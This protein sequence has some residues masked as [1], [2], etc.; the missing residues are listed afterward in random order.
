[1]RT[2]FEPVSLGTLKLRNRLVMSPMTR[3][4]CPTGV[5]TSDVEN[6]YVRRASA[7]VGLIITEGVW[8]DH[9]GASNDPAVPHFY[10]NAAELAWKKIATAIHAV[11]GAVIPQLWHVGC[12]FTPP[13][14]GDGPGSLRDDQLGP[15]GLAGGMGVF[16]RPMVRPATEREISE[17]I[18][19]FVKGGE[20][21]YRLGFDGVA[22][23]AAHGY[24]IDQFF[25]YVT[26]LRT[27]RYGG[28]VASRTRFATE[29]IREIRRRT[30][31][32]FPIMLRWSLWKSQDYDARALNTVA[33]MEA[34]LD[35]L[36]AAGV[37]IFDCSQRRFWEPIF[38]NSDLNLAGWTRKLTGKPTM[39]VGSVGLNL[40]LFASMTG[41]TCKPASLDRLEEMLA[42]G[43]FDLVGVGRALLSDPAWV[44]KVRDNAIDAIVPFSRRSLQRLY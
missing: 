30:H 31:P 23:H 9:P 8:V 36:V 25:W 32:E 3:S 34:F 11:G 39:T 4:F 7:D 33:E 26:N 42:R 44:L 18:E 24:L 28:D 20:V 10:G 27:D 43:D 29:I 17:M 14:N 5:P 6:Y 22:I 40:E 13:I 1:M 15:S 38:A 12:Y 35:P 16:P 19:A 41:E 21:A 2:L 37:D